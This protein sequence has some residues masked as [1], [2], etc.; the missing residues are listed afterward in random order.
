MNIKKNLHNMMHTCRDEQVKCFGLNG[1]NSDEIDIRSVS[2]NICDKISLYFNELIPRGGVKI[3][4]RVLTE[5]GYV[6]VGRC[7]GFS[8]D[9][10][11]TSTPLDR[12]EGLA[13]ILSDKEANKG[14]LIVNDIE[15]AAESGVYTIQPNDKNFNDYSTMMVAPMNGWSGEKVEMIGILFVTSPKERVFGEK[16]VDS[17]AFVADMCAVLFATIANGFMLGQRSDEE[18][19]E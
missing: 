4:I 2:D 7:G 13:R 14:M 12:N 6:T 1:K 17:V 16:H 15:L 9:R 18:G 8:K 5:D 11:A 3:A 10:A 19:D